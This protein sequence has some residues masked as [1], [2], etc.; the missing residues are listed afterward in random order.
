MRTKSYRE[1]Y[2]RMMRWYRQLEE[3]Y[4]GTKPFW[5]ELSAERTEIGYEKRGTIDFEDLIS[6]ADYNEDIVYIFFQNCYHLWEWI[7]NDPDLSIEKSVLTSFMKDNECLLICADI[8]NGSKHLKLRSATGD[9][10]T[11]LKEGRGSF[12]IGSNGEP[13]F[14]NTFKVESKGKYYDVLELAQE[15]IGKWDEFITFHNLPAPASM[16]SSIRSSEHR[17]VKEV[18]QVTNLK[19]TLEKELSSFISGNDVEPL[20]LAEFTQ[21]MEDKNILNY[22]IFPRAPQIPGARHSHYRF[23]VKKL[24]SKYQSVPR[25]LRFE[26]VTFREIE[27]RLIGITF[28]FRAIAIFRYSLSSAIDRLLKLEGECQQILQKLGTNTVK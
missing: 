7:L 14:E 1:Q 18:E 6:Y 13:V 15:C 3:L 17:T 21:I 5:T 10:S 28:D 12:S 11:R 26:A 8:C 27:D 2:N 9:E 4:A 22:C 20:D 25:V 24:N 23:V 16:K 19:E